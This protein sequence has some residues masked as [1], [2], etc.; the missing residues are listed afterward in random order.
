MVLLLQLKIPN[1]DDGTASVA[2]HQD[3]SNASRLL[4]VL[5]YRRGGKI[6]MVAS[7]QY[8]EHQSY[9]QVASYRIV[10]LIVDP[11][12]SVQDLAFKGKKFR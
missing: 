4:V 7:R 10:G 9:K 8:R 11:Q 5:C 12:G 3:G 6:E 2:K 1:L